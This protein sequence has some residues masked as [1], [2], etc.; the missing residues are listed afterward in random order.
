M[1][2]LR[3]LCYL[4]LAL[5]I[6]LVVAVSANAAPRDLDR[7]FGDDGVAITTVGTGDAY[8]TALAVQPDGKMLVAGLGSSPME[9]NEDIEHPTELGG[10]IARYERDG[11][12]DAT[13]G[14][15]DGIVLDHFG[16]E[17]S[18]IGAVA[19][20]ADGK[21][22]VAGSSSMYSSGLAVA[23]YL[24][25]GTR[26][27]EF[28]ENGLALLGMRLDSTSVSGLA[29]QHDGRIVVSGYTSSEDFEP[30]V[31]RLTTD[32]ERDPTYGNN[33]V[34]RLKLGY[35]LS[36]SARAHALVLQD[37]KAVIAGELY[38]GGTD[39]D[40]F[41]ARLD[42]S[43]KL[44]PTFGDGGVVHDRAGNDDQY[45]ASDVA[46]WSG[47]LIAAGWRG[48]DWNIQRNYLLA[49][50]DG[51][52]G[53]LDASF[54][55]EGTDPG[56]V[57]AGAGDANPR[58]DALAVDPA[59]GAITVAGTA[60][61]D[62]VSKVMVVR[63]LSDGSRDDVGFR[64]ANGNVGPR[65]I[66]LGDGVRTDYA[67][68]DVALDPQGGIVVAA[69][70][71]D[72]GRFKFALARLGDP[73]AKPNV[74]PVARIRGHHV[75]PRNTPVRFGGLRSSDPDGEIADYAWRVDGR[76]WHHVGPVFWH[77]FAIRG[78]HTITLRVRDDNG[79]FDFQTFH[80]NV[81]RGS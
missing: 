14:G 40:L 24:P 47:K 81:R 3:S 51:A 7:S 48:P 21:I 68:P 73:P 39:I 74:L 77:R 29:V 49:R 8:A 72:G 66:A 63:Y 79:A 5:A 41:L 30:F 52:D 19:V 12:L 57:F 35:P 6:A 76:R 36:P 22:V 61:D 20:Q 27:L 25:D 54:N 38:A 13:F 58:A 26:D 50:F 43:G 65:L 37:D 71:S 9:G 1:I 53:T 31:A 46:L 2:L 34:T 10:A 55:P 17:G 28:G 60:S 80:V 16:L 18:N 59:T 75:V 62:G 4:A 45:N 56:Y 78:P 33:G 64:S 23:R 67:E 15:G 44:D 70:A 32:G 42:E 11:S 69:T